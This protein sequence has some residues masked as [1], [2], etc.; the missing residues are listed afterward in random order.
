[1]EKLCWKKKQHDEVD[2]TAPSETNCE[3]T[4][5]I[6]RDEATFFHLSDRIASKLFDPKWN[7]NFYAGASFSQPLPVFESNGNS[8]YYAFDRRNN[9]LKLK[10]K[11]LKSICHDCVKT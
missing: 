11:Q 6:S 3:K 1:M 8:C 10:L 5:K 9:V 4:N 2:E 7:M